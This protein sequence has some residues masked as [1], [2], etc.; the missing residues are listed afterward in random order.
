MSL[1][2]MLV[3]D[4]RGNHKTAEVAEQWMLIVNLNDKGHELR[5]YHRFYTSMLYK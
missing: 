2:V 4:K 3:V 1:I 5:E